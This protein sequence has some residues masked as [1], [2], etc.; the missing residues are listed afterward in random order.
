MVR[1]LAILSLLLGSLPALAAAERVPEIE[2]RLNADIYYPGDMIE[3]SA[4]MHPAEY[5]AFSIRIPEHPKLHF[6]AYTPEPVRFQ[7]GAYVQRVVWRFQPVAAGEFVLEPIQARLNN[8]AGGV[9]T[10]TLPPVTIR[11][12]SYGAMD[13]SDELESLPPATS[14]LSAERNYLLLFLALA[15]VIAAGIWLIRRKGRHET[16]VLPVSSVGLA[17]LVLQ[18]EQGQ[19]VV[20]LI[21]QVVA[22]PD[23][24]LSA[25]LRAALEAA[26]YAGRMDRDHLLALI[27]SGGAS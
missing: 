25:E 3:L 22:R 10:V 2:L 14:G 16:A 18:L 15:A 26:A 24:Q 7:D 1:F 21:E 9:E 27:R 6:V 8:G 23:V 12:Q 19:P 17:D 11:V 4:V 20:K 5:A 13:T